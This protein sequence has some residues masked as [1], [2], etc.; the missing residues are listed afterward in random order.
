MKALK[1][2]IVFVVILGGVVLAAYLAGGG[3]G[4]G[5][6]IGEQSDFDVLK[7][8]ISKNWTEKG[9]WDKETFDKNMQLIN[10][11]KND[12]DGS[13]KTL[14]D[15]HYNEA[16]KIVYDKIIAQWASAS[17]SQAVVNKYYGAITTIGSN[18]QYKKRVASDA[19]IAKIRKIYSVYKD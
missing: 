4:I 18:E 19:N 14:Y 13:A 3:P 17:C 5:I 9:D 8:K 12:L 16:V 7:N 11:S 10:Q 1:L 6:S 15:Q 2:I